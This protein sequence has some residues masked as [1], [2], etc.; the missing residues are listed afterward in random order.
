MDGTEKVPA[1]VVGK[2]AS[3]RC[4]KGKRKL[5]VSYVANRKASMMREIFAQWLR[6]WDERLGKQ[7]RK[8]CLVLDNCTAH[9]TAVVLKNIELHFLP[10]NCTAAVQPLDQGVIMSFKSGYRKRVIDRILLNM[11]TKRDTVIDL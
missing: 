6:E 4:F 5:K 9:H 2:S 10:P 8:I 1:L 11:S 7:Q 3:P